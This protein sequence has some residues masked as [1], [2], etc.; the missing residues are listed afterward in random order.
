MAPIDTA[1]VWS[2]E[3]AEQLAQYNLRKK[4]ILNMKQQCNVPY[5]PLLVVNNIVEV[6]NKDLNMKRER[7][8]VENISYTSGS[9]TMQI[10]I[11]N[12]TNLPLIGGVNYGGQ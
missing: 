3:A 12:I 10:E 4:S 1:N 11:S 8:V 2:D 5:N 9:S 6:E 7:Y